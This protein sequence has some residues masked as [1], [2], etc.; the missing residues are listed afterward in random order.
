M[1]IE[2]DL[3]RRSLAAAYDLHR[4]RDAGS[5]P[6]HLV[7]TLAA[8]LP[9][10]SAVLATFEPASGELGL[11]T[12][13]AGLF[14]RLDG[15]EAVRL[16][17]EGHPFVALCRRSRSV[18]AHRLCDLASREEFLRTELYTKLY[19]FLGI[20]HQLLILVAGADAR[21][22]A[23]VL[24]RRE[25]EF[26]PAE[27]AA[28]ES[29]WP[30]LT[31]A[32]RNLRRGLHTRAPAHLE[33]AP[34]DAASVIVIRSSGAVTLCTE[35]ARLW[36][37][38]F[39]DAVFLSKGVALPAPLFAWAAKRIG[40]EGEGRR[41][42]VVRRDPFV[43][44]H[45]DHCLVADLIVDHGKDTHLMRLEKVALNAP[46]ASLEALGLTPREAEVLTWV[47]QGKTNREVGMILG[48]SARTVQKHL[49]HIF[50]KIG[51]ESRTAAIL[52][53]WQAGRHAALA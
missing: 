43:I 33:G 20:E 32:Q 45:G 41:L 2:E 49:E 34:D 15:A 6:A 8:M 39:F 46:A 42:R 38:E 18:R 10:D 11:E 27:R 13:P 16:H 23:L 44:A 14:E 19:R 3:L 24:N 28:L 21:W 7:R 53:A 40:D 26:S 1:S 12:W 35:R 25:P 52:K 50:Q 30:H 36:L 5:Y 31:L 29:L 4:H 37:A 17:A 47:A 48:S 51:V 9:C 22:R